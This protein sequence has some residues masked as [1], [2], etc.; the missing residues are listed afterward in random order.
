MDQLMV[1]CGD[2][3]VAIGDEVVLIGAPGRRAHRGVGLGGAGGHD[4]LRDRVRVRAPATP[5]LRVDRD[6]RGL[7][8]HVDEHVVVVVDPDL[9]AARRRQRAPGAEHRAPER[10]LVGN[11]DRTEPGAVWRSPAG[12]RSDLKFT[13]RIGL[14]ENP[15]STVVP[16]QRGSGHVQRAT[17]VDLG[18]QHRHLLGRIGRDP[19]VG[20][21]DGL[22]VRAVLAAHDADAVPTLEGVGEL[23]PRPTAGRTAWSGTR[24]G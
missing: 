13:A 12:C 1:D 11:R 19:E 5:A 8:Q 21:G 14:C 18:R 4:R 10:Q 3:D 6:R 22:A 20:V 2:D 15:T 17:T 23:R 9:V 7:G 24:R 16:G